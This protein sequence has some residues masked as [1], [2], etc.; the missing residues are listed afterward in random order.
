MQDVIEDR[1]QYCLSH[2][3]GEAK[4]CEM[5][6]GTGRCQQQA[7]GRGDSQLAGVAPGKQ[8]QTEV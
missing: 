6:C 7:A 1:M 8:L 2:V 5:C 3:A 4:E